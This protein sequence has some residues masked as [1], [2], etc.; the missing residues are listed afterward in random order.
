MLSALT[1]FSIPL[2]DPL[3]IF[4]FLLIIILIVP[5]L[6]NKARLP[7]VIG[8]IV[9]GM[10][11]GPYGINLLQQGSIMTLF[12]TVGLLYIMFLAGI[13]LD[14]VEFR[15]NRYRSILFGAF[16]FFIPLLIGLPACLYI[17]GFGWKASILV[18]SMFATHT[19]VS[20]PIAS[21]LGVIRDE[22]ATVT[23][24]GTLITDTAVL[25]ILAVVTAGN[26]ASLGLFFWIS[27]II[28]LLVLGFIIF[29]LFPI[30]GTWFFRNA[31]GDKI[32]QFVFII[33]MVFIA[34]VL[35]ELAGV[36]SIIGAFIAGLALNR[37]VPHTS[38][39]MNRIEFFGNALF[40]PVF[41]I[42]VGMLVNLRVIFSGWETVTVAL[43][44]TCVALLGKWLAAWLTQKSFS[45]SVDQRQLIFGLSSSHAAATVAVI[46]V[47][48]NEG[49]VNESV[50]NGTI[51]LIFLSCLIS[52][53]V[54]E[55]AGRSLA[56]SQRNK[57]G[58]T[59]SFPERI[60]IPVTTSTLTE[61]LIDFAL[62]LKA[63]ESK[64]SLYALSVVQDDDHAW[65]NI[66]FHHKKLEKAAIHAASTDTDLRTVTRVDVNAAS[67][68][69][70]SAKEL[71]ISDIVIAGVQRIGILQRLF[72]TMLSNILRNTW[73]TVYVSHVTQ[74]LNTFQR[75]FIAVPPNAEAEEGFNRWVQHVQRLASRLSAEIFFFVSPKTFD[76]LKGRFD[77]AGVK[78]GFK[79][80]RTIK[81]FPRFLRDVKPED[82]VVLVSS[83]MGA[84]S[85]DDYLDY[86]TD[87]LLRSAQARK[88]VIVY[89]EQP[90]APPTYGA[91]FDGEF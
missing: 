57:Q 43:V 30:I 8:L 89:P 71:M 68:I 54:T 82:L 88:V 59:P 73:Q 36:E 72:G 7:S 62:M 1:H 21:R 66:S 18:A 13:E 46:L 28:Q 6:F 42:S 34:A 12:G 45:Y 84:V 61:S 53:F 39:L 48:Y 91:P 67:G 11:V 9:V 70:R 50:L 29:Y 85:Y 38:P 79:I 31:E 78:V 63:P 58:E 55:H 49:I 75:L 83:R 4:C 20:Y 80:Y 22:S 64:E 47:A 65:Q 44:L 26:S 87:H 15:R 41:L 74:P 25:M 33:T 23:V 5:P 19:L 40:I 77:E 24:G 76:V 32:S 37:L 3:Q 10:I 60:L 16:T 35:S 56:I 2:Q 51:V 27:W 17:L 69:A 52:A 14:V 90:V 86:V 81:Y